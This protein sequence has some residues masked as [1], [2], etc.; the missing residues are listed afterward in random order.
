MTFKEK[1][2]FVVLGTPLFSKYQ[3]SL[4]EKEFKEKVRGLIA[5]D[6]IVNP[7]SLSK[8]RFLG[9]FHGLYNREFTIKPKSSF[10]NRDSISNSIK[11]HGEIISKGNS[12]I[13]LE[14]SFTRTKQLKAGQQILIGFLGV[15]LLAVI[16]RSI[17]NSDISA[18]FVFAFALFGFYLFFTLISVFQTSGQINYFERYFVDQFNVNT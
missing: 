6:D 15:L 12:Y 8:V 1:V 16:S 17:G 14:V 11:V 13:E 9:Y 5:A 4:N 3:V 10:W 18:L 2:I 7:F